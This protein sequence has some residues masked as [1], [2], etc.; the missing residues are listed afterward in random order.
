MPPRA[1]LLFLLPGL[2]A[3]VLAGCAGGDAPDDGYALRLADATDRVDAA[4]REASRLT[5]LDE[6]AAALETLAAALEGEA[7]ELAAV[8][9]PDS[10]RDANGRLVDA[11]REY[12]ADLRR[13]RAALADGSLRTIADLLV[14]VS[15]FDSGD[16]LSEA[17]DQLR[18][19]GYDA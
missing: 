4:A 17:R 9:A 6:P 1:L 3:I 19:L 5:T 14:R 2:V 8:A 18:T 16:A 13:A 10:A 12:A 11:M 15:T 7:G